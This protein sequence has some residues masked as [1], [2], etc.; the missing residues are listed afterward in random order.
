MYH[1]RL[2]FDAVADDKEKER[3]AWLASLLMSATGNYGKK[4][5]EA[6]KLYK[7]A[8]DDEGRLI[9]EVSE[10]NGSPF[11]P[12]DKDEKDAKLNELMKQFNIPVSQG[13]QS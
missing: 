5:I 4:G 2:H 13:G 12:I 6:K 10:S 8:F 9:P 7:R 11:T 1:A 3:T